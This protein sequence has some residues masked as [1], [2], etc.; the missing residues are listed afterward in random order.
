MV[1]QPLNMMK[2]EFTSQSANVGFAR[3]A[4][5]LFASPMDFTLDEIDEI[6]I[7]VSEAV[8]NAIIHGQGNGTRVVR[9]ETT[10][11]GDFLT[12][13][14]SDDGPGIADIEWA[15]QPGSTTES[16]R[17][18]LGFVFMREYMDEI[19]VDSVPSAGTTVHM[20]KNLVRDV[21]G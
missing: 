15:M 17:M 16:D 5:A 7:A 3:T 1:G 13:T 18:G 10:L 8:S 2:L 6:K 11:Y 20:R 21:Q 14:V 19:K 4:V 9:L 12:I